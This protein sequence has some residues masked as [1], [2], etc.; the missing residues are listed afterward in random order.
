MCLFVCLKHE[1]DE[2]HRTFSRVEIDFKLFKKTHDKL[3]NR[4][5]HHQANKM[6][7]ESLETWIWNLNDK[8]EEFPENVHRLDNEYDQGHV[9]KQVDAI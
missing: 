6:R 1:A 4:N 3:V 8:T 9:E 2:R 5:K 7:I